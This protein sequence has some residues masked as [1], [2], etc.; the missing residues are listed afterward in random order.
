[1]TGQKLPRPGRGAARPIAARGLCA[2]AVVLAVM[3]A[4]PAPAE[5]LDGADLTAPPMIDADA[6]PATLAG[7]LAKVRA[8][9]TITLGYRDASF[10][11]SYVRPDKPEPMGYS[12]DLC[13]GVVG[14]IVREFQGVPVK[15]VFAPVT[16]DTRID[17]VTS[18][19]VDLECGSTTD[20]IERRKSVAFSPLIF[21]AGTKLLT[22]RDSGIRTLRDL[23]GRMLVVTSGTTNERAM[24]NANDKYKLGITIVSAAD[25]EA[26]YDV[27]ASGKADAFA[28]DDVLLNGLIVSHNAG[29]TMQVVGDFL[30][31][32][33][34]GL[35]YRKDDPQMSG[36]V[37]RAFAAMAS[38]G[39]LVANYHKWFLSPTP[40]GENIELPMSLQL[41]E[42]LRAMGVDDF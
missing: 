7:T 21:V 16:S 26:S 40:T 41:T 34:Y 24:R 13:K 28:T 38:D 20:N 6:L 12:I 11:F 27:L 37:R 4:S 18:D 8:N 1:M 10:P 9:G 23:T 22:R 31:Y 32:E 19:K 5:D 29:A 36:L 33:P 2:L 42:A 35:M 25:H 3:A 17:A 39:E 30:T 15:I 14:E